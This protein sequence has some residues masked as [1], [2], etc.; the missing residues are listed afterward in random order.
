MQAILWMNIKK[1]FYAAFFLFTN[2]ICCFF[3]QVE[4]NA[5]IKR[6][7]QGG[8]RQWLQCSSYTGEKVINV[9]LYRTTSNT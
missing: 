1:F 3:I 6:W 5:L 2:W 8:D 7:F 4:L 9:Y